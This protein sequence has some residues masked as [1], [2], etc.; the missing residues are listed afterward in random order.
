[1]MDFRNYYKNP[2][3]SNRI[4]DD[5]LRMFTQ[6]HIQRTTANNNSGIYTA[7]LNAT[8]PLFNAFA[9]GIDDENLRATI[10]KGETRQAVKL[11]DLFIKTTARRE[12]TV[13]SVFG[14]DSPEYL[15]FFPKGLTE[16]AKPGIAKAMTLMK[17]METATAQYAA[18]LGA[19]IAA[20]FADIRA[21][22]ELLRNK[23]LLAFGD[24]ERL[25]S[26]T[27]SARKALVAQLYLNLLFIASQ[28]VGHPDRADDFMDQ[29]IIRPSRKK[30]DGKKVL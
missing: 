26:I 12:G 14:A 11:L 4:G 6:D 18:Q 27:A 19:D 3:D 8:T 21:Q 5:N 24:V 25:R 28:N 9:K 13:R 1:M 10:K 29:T 2:F 20:E 22:Y 16:Y 15:M 7:I 30:A 17:R 23:Q